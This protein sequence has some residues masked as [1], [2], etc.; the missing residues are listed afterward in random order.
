LAY[1]LTEDVSKDNLAL[2]SEYPFRDVGVNGLSGVYLSRV[3]SLFARC[4]DLVYSNVNG[5]VVRYDAEGVAL[6]KLAYSEPN[7]IKSLTNN[8]LKKF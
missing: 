8:F 2:V 6:K 5:R 3:G 1:M 4:G 7:L